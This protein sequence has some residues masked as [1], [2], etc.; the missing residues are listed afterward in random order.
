MAAFDLVVIGA[1][2]AGYV[3][4][5]R[6]AQLGMNVALI[7]REALGGTC[8][9]IGC[10]PSKALL[11]ATHEYYLA[12]NKFSSRGIKVGDVSIDLPTL[13]SFKQKVVRQLTG[14]VGS[15]VKKN[16]ITHIKGNARLLSASTVEVTA[17]GGKQTVEAKRILIATGS[18]PVE[19]PAAKV[20]GK[21][22]VDSTG[23][24][25][26][27]SIPKKL[28]VIGAGAIGLELGSVWSRLGSEV[29]YVEFLQN[30]AGAADAEIA[31]LL[32][33]SLEKQGMSFRLGAKV[34]ATS[35]KGGK[36]TVTYETGGKSESVEVD[37]VLVSVGRKPAIEGLGL[38]QIGVKLTA[39]GAIEVREH[40]QTAVDGVYAVGDCIGGAMLAHKA[41][42]EAIACVERMAGVGGHVNYDAIPNIIYT[43]PELASVGLSEEQ[44]KQKGHEVKVGKFPFTANGRAKS[45]DE[46]E[47]TVKIVADGRTDRVLGVTILH[48]RASELIAEAAIAMEYS[49]SSEDIARSVHAH[50]TLSEALKEAALAVDGRAI[51][52]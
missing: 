4:A 12:K 31:A 35:I 22:I 44:A 16:K 10:I 42:D 15:L 32:Q 9:N 38:E 13:M 52:F 30:I 28:L 33:K 43:A 29:T 14:G 8:L 37:R 41:S 51:H 47:G 6:A 1:G 40:Y 20:D 23:A 19:L 18:K 45:M 34:T 27:D 11:D 3:G 46:V 5:I 25:S 24:L 48:A 7:E 36:V 39:R 26:F 21:H 49:A 50:P 2:P 17:E